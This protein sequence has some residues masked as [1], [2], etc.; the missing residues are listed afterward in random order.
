MLYKGSLLRGEFNLVEKIK[1]NP[2]SAPL[3]KQYKRS[4]IKWELVKRCDCVIFKRCNLEYTTK[5]GGLHA[6]SVKGPDG[7]Y[8]RL[9]GIEA[10]LLC[11]E[12]S[13]RQ[14]VNE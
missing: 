11:R 2:F 14:Y 9:C 7:K 4:T 6:F 5:E 13:Y 1:L 8:L 12:S 10:A 3:R